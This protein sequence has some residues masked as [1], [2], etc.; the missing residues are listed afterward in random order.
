MKSATKK[1]LAVSVAIA[2]GTPMTAMATNGYFGH[3]IGMKSMGMGGAGIAMAQDSLASA[4][5]PATAALTGN[6]I[7]FGLNLFRPDR[8]ARVSG[9][10]AP[11]VNG[12]YDGNETSMFLIPE[13]G[14]SRDL[15]HGKA[16]V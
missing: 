7:D 9:S 5:N 8:E 11:G 12:T 16:L 6:R 1:I 10:P 14:Y 15:G 4:T 2:L 13:F 3:G